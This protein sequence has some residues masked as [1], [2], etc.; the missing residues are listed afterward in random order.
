MSP[1]VL[2]VSQFRDCGMGHSY[3][4]TRNWIEDTQK[5]TW[6]SWKTVTSLWPA[7]PE[8]PQLAKPKHPQAVAELGL[9]AENELNNKSYFWFWC[10]IS[11]SPKHMRSWD[12]GEIQ[13]RPCFPWWLKILK[14]F[15]TINCVSKPPN[16]S[17]V[18]FFTWRFDWFLWGSLSSICWA[19]GQDHPYNFNVLWN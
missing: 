2:R 16:L 19:R 18:K 13:R 4:R 10:S 14:T 1:K 6:I 17:E 12:C 7:Y 9:V 15:S 11:K 5:H 8:A 3:P